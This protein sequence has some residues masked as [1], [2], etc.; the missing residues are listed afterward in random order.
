MALKQPLL[1]LG[2]LLEHAIFTL[3][4]GDELLL[5][6][7]IEHRVES[8][9]GHSQKFSSLLESFAAAEIERQ[10]RHGNTSLSGAP[11]VLYID[12]SPSRLQLLSCTHGPGV[13]DSNCGGQLDVMV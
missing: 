1:Q 8:V 2:A 4:Q 3:R 10:V 5:L 13:H 6:I 11:T 7:G 12:S 9:S